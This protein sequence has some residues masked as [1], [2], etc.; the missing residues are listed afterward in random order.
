[1]YNRYRVFPGDK[2]WP[3]RDSDPSP[4]SNAVV[5]KEYSYTS[6]PCMELTACTQSQCLYN[7]AIF[8]TMDLN[9]SVDVA[10]FHYCPRH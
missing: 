8:I 6:T 10:V 1:M 9:G 3:G 7:G 5:K 4:P 2:E